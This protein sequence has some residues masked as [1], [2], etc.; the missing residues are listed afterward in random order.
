NLIITQSDR[1]A[2]A[3][4]GA[5]ISDLVSTYLYVGP[6]F[7][8][9]DFFRTEDHQFRI[10]KSLFEN[11]QSYLKNSP[12]LLVSSVKTPLLTWTGA[13]DRQV[14]AQQSLELFLALRRLNKKH[15]LLVY[16]DEEHTIEKKQNA[17]DLNMRI[18]QWLNYYLKGDKEKEW[19]STSYN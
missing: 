6:T 4:S 14:N 8:R 3:V 18:L 12:V 17:L 16:P 13:E 5:G 11:M 10:G 9:P 19:F 2:A 15:V 1:F 7:R